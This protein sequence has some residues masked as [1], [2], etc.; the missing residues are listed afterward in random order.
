MLES[1]SAINV[2]RMEEAIAML[3][4]YLD[5]QA[6]APVLDIMH[7]LTK[8]PEDGALLNRLFVTVEGMGIMQGAML[9]YAPYIAILMSEHQFQEPD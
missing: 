3:R 6:L 5:A 2:P 8:N 9:T 1:N 4:Q 7:E